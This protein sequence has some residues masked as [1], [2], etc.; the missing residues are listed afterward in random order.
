MK[1][2]FQAVFQFLRENGVKTVASWSVSAGVQMQKQLLR[3][4]YRVSGII[5]QVGGLST[6][7]KQYCIRQRIPFFSIRGIHDLDHAEDSVNFLYRGGHDISTPEDFDALFKKVA[8]FLTKKMKTW[9]TPESR[10]LKDID[11]ILDAGHT[12]SSL[13]ANAFRNIKESD[14]TFELAS[15]V[16]KECLSK[17]K[18]L[19]TRSGQP[20][21]EDPL[22]TL[23]RRQAILTKADRVRALSLHFNASP[24]IER[25]KNLSSAFV[26][27]EAN[28]QDI[29]FAR[30]LIRELTAINLP[31]KESYPEFTEQI[32]NK[33]EPGIFSRK[34][35]LLKKRSAA[36][37]LLESAYYDDEQEYS[38]LSNRQWMVEEGLW[39]RPRLKQIA[40]A[41]CSA[42]KN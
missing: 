17:K 30:K 31:G 22:E 16:N 38:R 41:I 4:G 15:L 14:L 3:E 29:D 9:G 10:P 13:D 8:P 23:K 21:W 25:S 19:L 12:G 39:Q 1:E 7:L 37:V 27:W 18:I 42:L 33:L 40:T 5:D 2:F 28:S 6:S 32:I 35:A 36:T 24:R 26:P 11:F 34:L 20:S